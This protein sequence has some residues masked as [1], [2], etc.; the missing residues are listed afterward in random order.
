MFIGADRHGSITTATDSRITPIGKFL[1]TWKLDEFP[2]LFNVLLGKMSFVGPRPDVEGYA[3]ILEGDD[4]KV[5]ELRP[6]ITG[7]AT[8]F[9]RYEEELLA[10]VDDPVAFNDNVIWPL[11]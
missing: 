11:K 6:G 10:Q 2:Q 3:D 4:R 8:V 9:F 7:P 1:R 5:L